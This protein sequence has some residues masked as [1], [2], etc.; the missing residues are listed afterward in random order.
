MDASRDDLVNL[1]AAKPDLEVRQLW[2]GR[3]VLNGRCMMG[4][5]VNLSGPFKIDILVGER[6][7]GQVGG[8]LLVE[9]RKGKYKKTDYDL[10]I[11]P[12][13]TVGKP[14]KEDLERMK[15]FSTKIEG[16][17]GG[18]ELKDIPIFMAGT[19]AD[20]ARS[21]LNPGIGLLPPKEK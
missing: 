7:G 16:Q 21:M 13:F 12:L 10:P 17:I 11:L 3:G 8:L 9:N 6:P 15:D 19:A 1:E 5:W 18:L 14:D 4:K 2:G 20:R